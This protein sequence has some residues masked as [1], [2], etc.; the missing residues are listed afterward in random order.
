MV[1][2][3]RFRRVMSSIIRCRRGVMGCSLSEV[4]REGSTLIMA[5]AKHAGISL[6]QRIIGDTVSARDARGRGLEKRAA[7]DAGD[8]RRP[9]DLPRSGLVQLAPAPTEP[10]ARW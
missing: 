4:M 7:V 5:Q 6:R 9:R 8:G 1:R 2:G 10:N 3:A